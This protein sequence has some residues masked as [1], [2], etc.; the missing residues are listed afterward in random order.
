MLIDSVSKLYSKCGICIGVLITKNE[1]VRN[2]VM[3]FWHACLNSPLIGQ[4]V[5]EASIEGT[6]VYN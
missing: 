3:R 4:I 5:A 1:S 2:T 6:E